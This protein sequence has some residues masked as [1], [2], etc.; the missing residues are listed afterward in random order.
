MK[1][2][3]LKRILAI[4]ALIVGLMPIAVAEPVPEYDMKAAYL[5]NFALFTTWPSRADN[6]VR[7]CVFGKDRFG[8]ALERLAGNPA[9]GVRIALSYLPSLQA[10]NNCQIL[11]IDASVRDSAVEIL[12]QLG[13]FPVLTVTDS[14]DLFQAGVM[15]G[16]FLENNR[17]GFDVN[18]AQAQNVSLVMS[19]KLLRIARKVQQ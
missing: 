19:S 4:P 1:Y 5:Y 14:P 3:S 15:I 7:L 2:P 18:Y 12:N 9:I 10:A 16:L 6:N 8:G 17:L 13:K 11:F